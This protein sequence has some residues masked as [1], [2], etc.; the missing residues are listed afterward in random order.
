MIEL[1]FKMVDEKEIEIVASIQ[2]LGERK[3]GRI[4]TPSSNSR[5]MPNAIQICGFK[6]AFD[7]WGCGVFKHMGK[8]RRRGKFI[9][10]DSSAK[11]IQLLFDFNTVPSDASEVIGSCDRCFNDPCSCPLVVKS[12]KDVDAIKK[13]D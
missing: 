13:E 10:W 6:E 8:T 5:D 3:V 2:G 7:L 9:S 1:K 11:D 4:F 12:G